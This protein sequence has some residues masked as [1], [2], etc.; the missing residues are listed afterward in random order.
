MKKPPVKIVAQPSYADTLTVASNLRERDREEIFATRP[1]ENPADLARDVI[2]SGAF[3][4]GAYVDNRPVAAIGAFQRWP[5]VW[6]VWAFG[7][8]EWR[9]AAG[10]LTKYAIRNMRPALYR[11]GALRVDCMSLATHTDARRWLELLG[12]RPEKT[13]DNWGK[14]G[15]S[16]VLYSWTRNGQNGRN[17]HV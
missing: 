12:L 3:R 9:S 16:F 8:D 17:F 13:L 4:W 2:A 15:E 6:S 5:N 11:S 10:A 14:A 7:T 1:D